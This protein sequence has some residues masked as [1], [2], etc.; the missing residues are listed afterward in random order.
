MRS[1]GLQPVREKVTAE[2]LPARLVAVTREREAALDEGKLAVIVPASRVGELTA[3]VS[4]A[5]PQASYGA[6]PD[7]DRRVVVL[8]A[9]QAKGLEFD[10]VVLADPEAI[11]ADGPR[12]EN[13]LYVALTRTTRELT[14][15]EVG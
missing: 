1:S 6:L 12:G 14:V 10:S 7:L 15:L 2:E 5:L 11:A 13:D 9:R 3:A 4:A 8:T